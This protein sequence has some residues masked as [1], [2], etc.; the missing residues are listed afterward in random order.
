MLA[1]GMIIFGLGLVVV[2][3]CVMSRMSE[4]RR[5]PDCGSL[6]SKMGHIIRYTGYAAKFRSQHLHDDPFPSER[7]NSCK[8]K[9]NP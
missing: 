5:C 7:C 9:L 3:S 6:H 8:S 1:I 2:G 4:F